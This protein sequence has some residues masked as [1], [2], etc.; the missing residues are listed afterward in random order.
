MISNMDLQGVVSDLE[1]LNATEKWNAFE[2]LL[3]L[4]GKSKLEVGSLWPCSNGQ[5]KYHDK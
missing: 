5:A 1:V 2:I 4:F 3:E